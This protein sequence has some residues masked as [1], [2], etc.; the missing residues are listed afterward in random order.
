[1]WLITTYYWRVTGVNK[2]LMT[3]YIKCPSK[4]PTESWHEH[5]QS[6]D[7]FKEM[8]YFVW[9]LITWNPKKD[10]T[11]WVCD[12]QWKEASIHIVYHV[13]WTFAVWGYSNTVDLLQPSLLHVK[14]HQIAAIHYN[15]FPFHKRSQFAVQTTVEQPQKKLMSNECV[16]VNWTIS[17]LAQSVNSH[18]SKKTFLQC[19]LHSGDCCSKTAGHQT[20][21]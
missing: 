15:W 10:V 6:E 21:V 2:Q 7:K 12:S 4:V 3:G 16:N 11:L 5:H 18:S 19:S 13:R 9:C 14:S 17:S 20:F 8:M 1:M